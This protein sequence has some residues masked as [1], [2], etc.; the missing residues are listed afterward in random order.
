MG[1]FAETQVV[2]VA[3]T[4]DD[5]AVRSKP[6]TQKLGCEACAHLT[7]GDWPRVAKR[8]ENGAGMA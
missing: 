7:P 2:K 6:Q 8:P 1:M 3:L 5:S 4:Q